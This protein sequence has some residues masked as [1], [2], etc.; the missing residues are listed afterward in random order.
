MVEPELTAHAP[1]GVAFYATRVPVV[2]VER[3]EDK[4][5]SIVAM[6]D[7]VPAAAAE[8]GSLQPSAVIFACTSASFLD[9]RDVDADTC[10]DL[11]VA[12][13]AP[14]CTTSTAV[15]TALQALGVERLAVVTPYVAPVGDGA[16][17]YLEQSGFT[18]TAR[19]DLG[20]LSNL[21]KG[22]L[23]VDASERL[24][25]EVD[26]TGADAV[27]ISCTNWRSLD[28]L[29]SLERDLGL[30][31]VSSNLASLWAGLRLAGVH[32][33]GP[34]VALMERPGTTLLERLGPVGAEAPA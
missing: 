32:A 10:A 11:S 25:R 17:R 31:V 9:G 1:P 3:Q 28:R 15:V 7:R 30:P 34:D 8:L 13:N 18:V 24:A 2:E 16:V 22:E 23:P 27:L 5:A 21:A 29:A 20:L 33:G 6:R 26:L 14:A 4:V 19:R 12:A